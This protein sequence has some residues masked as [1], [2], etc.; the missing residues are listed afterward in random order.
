MTASSSENP[1]DYHRLLTR[2]DESN[3]E[4]IHEAPKFLHPGYFHSPLP[5]TM[6]TAISN[7]LTCTSSLL[8][9]FSPR[10]CTVSAPT[11]CCFQHGER[12][13]MLSLFKNTSTSS[14]TASHCYDTSFEPHCCCRVNDKKGEEKYTT[15]IILY[16]VPNVVQSLASVGDMLIPVVLEQLQAL[17]TSHM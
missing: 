6:V 9:T 8:Y 11:L 12:I 13:T 3:G 7:L 16:D 10:K 17:Q 14:T 2:D 5:N 4:V 15:C 1:E